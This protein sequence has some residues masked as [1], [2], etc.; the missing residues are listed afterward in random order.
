MDITLCKTKSDFGKFLQREK[1]IKE[2]AI[3]QVEIVDSF[4]SLFEESEAVW[5]RIWKK[6]DIQ[7]EGD[8]ISQKL[9]RMICL[10]CLNLVMTTRTITN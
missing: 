7:V 2:Q 5:E 8:R 1:N 4:D 9:L 6:V 3:E 10:N